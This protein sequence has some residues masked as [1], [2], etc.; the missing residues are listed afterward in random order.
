MPHRWNPRSHRQC[1]AWLRLSPKG[2]ALIAWGNAHLNTKGAA[3]SPLRK[4]LPGGR[5]VMLASLGPDRTAA[6]TPKEV[7][8]V[9]ALFAPIDC[10]HCSQSPLS[11][12]RH[13]GGQKGIFWRPAQRCRSRGAKATRIDQTECSGSP[14]ACQRPR[15]ADAGGRGCVPLF[16]AAARP[17]SARTPGRLQCRFPRCR[18]RSLRPLWRGEFASRRRAGPRR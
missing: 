1:A 14:P 18:R 10:C 7:P 13:V 15:R 12:A 4:A 9:S 2:G 16:R 17:T 11:S 6:A 3:F 8:L 5:W